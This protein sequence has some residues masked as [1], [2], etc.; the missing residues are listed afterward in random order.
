MESKPIMS[1]SPKEI[2]FDDKVKES[3]DLIQRQINNKKNA[4]IKQ[5]LKE[6]GKLHIFKN[7]AKQRFK[8]MM[9]EISPD[10]ETV[11]IDNGTLKGQ[12]VVT[13]FKLTEAEMNDAEFRTQ[14]R[15]Y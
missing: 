12:R 8:K 3:V 14:I 13:F 11:W 4:I 9:I 1:T 10:K 15:F 5:R 2:E 6:M 7:L